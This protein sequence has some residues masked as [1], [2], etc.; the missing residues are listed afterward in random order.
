MTL[1]QLH[2][3]IFTSE[4]QDIGGG[5]VARQLVFCE[6]AVRRG[7][8]ATFYGELTEP[9]RRRLAKLGAHYVRVEPSV[10]VMHDTIR[11]SNRFA[12]SNSVV[13]IDQYSL[14][15]IIN[16][17]AHLS[18]RI[19]IFSDGQ[20]DL[21]GSVFLQVDSALHNPHKVSPLLRA[22]NRL[23]GPQ[24][25]II[26]SK[27]EDVRSYRSAV[28]KQVFSGLGSFGLSDPKDASAELFSAWSRRLTGPPL[29]IVLGPLY[30][31]GLRS[32][33]PQASNVR[34]H[35]HGKLSALLATSSFAIGAS[36]L[37]AYERAFLGLPSILVP[38][39]QN[40]EGI[41]RILSNAGAAIV[42]KGFSKVSALEEAVEHLWD[43]NIRAKMSLA[44]MALVNTKATSTILNL[45]ETGQNDESC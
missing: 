13:V 14:F 30:A 45:L 37:S 17:L 24:A 40:Q 18:A 8:N 36:G 20:S 38:Q 41:A 6:Q 16:D 2:L 19:I 12:A 44:G 39:A 10:N 11:R 26:P 28:T 32:L 29:S 22:Q 21:A 9:S 33:T 25:A 23:T 3:H 4:S 35:K 5:H 42:L 15:P 34:I 27:L 43:P 1:G 7:H 31:G